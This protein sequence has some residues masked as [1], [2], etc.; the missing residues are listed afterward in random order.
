M[1]YNYDIPVLLEFLDSVN[2]TNYLGVCYYLELH[3]ALTT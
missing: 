1:F 2:Y 3:G